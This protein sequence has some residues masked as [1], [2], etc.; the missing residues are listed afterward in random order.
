MITFKS[1][2]LFEILRRAGYNKHPTK[3]MFAGGFIKYSQGGRFHAILNE[4]IL[5][6]KV[7]IHFDY[8]RNGFHNVSK[9]IPIYNREKR[10]LSKLSSEYFLSGKRKYKPDTLPQA[11]LQELYKNTI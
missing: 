3:G 11:Q 1:K 10:L 4:N 5:S 7:E 6:K 2:N 8:T 9:Y